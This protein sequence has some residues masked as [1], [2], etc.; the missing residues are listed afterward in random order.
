[1]M[2]ERQDRL[3]ATDFYVWWSLQCVDL[4]KKVNTFLGTH[5][6]VA[7]ALIQYRDVFGIQRAKSGLSETGFSQVQKISGTTFNEGHTLKTETLSLFTSFR[8]TFSK[9]S[10]E[11]NQNS[12]I[13]PD[14]YNLLDANSIRIKH[15]TGTRKRKKQ[16]S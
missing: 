5:R 2:V 8:Q 10:Q 15:E 7:T 16:T 9:L 6:Q 14:I 12:N 4:W 13:F 3:T 11:V 1:M